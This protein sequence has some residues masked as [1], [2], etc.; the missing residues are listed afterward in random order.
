MKA[1]ENFCMSTEGSEYWDI[2]EESVFYR[3]LLFL[4]LVSK[5][6]QVLKFRV[7]NLELHYPETLENIIFHTGSS[8]ILLV[9]KSKEGI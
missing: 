5:G 7:L 2:R 9:K 6:I 1:K 8:H 4:N 3:R